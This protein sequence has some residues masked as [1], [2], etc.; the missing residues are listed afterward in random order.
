MGRR[1]SSC[2]PACTLC[3]I[4]IFIKNLLEFTICFLYITSGGESQEFISLHFVKESVMKRSL[5]F[6]ALLLLIAAQLYGGERKRIPMY[7]RTTKSWV[8]FPFYTIHDIEFVSQDS[9]LKA[10]TL[11]DNNARWTLQASRFGIAPAINDNDSEIVT[12]GLVV[13]P[14]FVITYTGGGLT[15]LLH[16][17]INNYSNSWGGILLRYPVA[18]TASWDLNGYGSVEKGDLIYVTAKVNDYPA[19]YMNSTTELVPDTNYTTTVVGHNIPIPA[20]TLVDITDLNHGAYNS[21]G[22]FSKPYSIAEQY[23]NSL[24]ELTGLAVTNYLNSGRQLVL[25]GAGGNQLTDYDWSYYF[26]IGNAGGA[27]DPNFHQP[28]VGAVMDTIRG[29]LGTTSGNENSDGYRIIPLYP[30]DIVWGVTLPL[31]SAHRRNPVVVTPNDSVQVQVSMAL[32]SGGLPLYKCVIVK[33]I[34]YG[35]WTVDTLG[36]Y[37]STSNPDSTIYA[38]YILDQDG[39]PWPLGTNVRYFF[40][41]IDNFGDE[42]IYANASGSFGRD[43]TRGFFFYNVGNGSL[44]IHDV[45]YTPYTNGRSAYAGGVTSLS[46]IV[47]ADTTVM[48]LSPL[49]AT[50]TGVG[51]NA[52]YIQNGSGPWNGIWVISTDSLSAVQLAAMRLG[53]SVVVYGA[54]EE[55]FEVTTL[56]DSTVAIVAHNRP[57]PAPVT[58]TTATLGVRGNGDP[59]GEQWEGCLVRV[60]NARFMDTAAYYTNIT[61]YG[62]DDGTGEMH[63]LRDGRNNYSNHGADTISGDRIFNIGDRVDTMIGIV[64]YSYNQYKLVPRSNADIVA[65]EPFQYQKDWNLVSVGRDQQPAIGAYTQGNLF[66]GSLGTPFA[67]EGRYVPVTTTLA[68]DEGYWLKFPAT[69]TIRQL[70][71]KHT[72]DFIP[73]NPGWNIIGAIGDSVPVSPV[74]PS[75]PGN[76]LS[77][78]FGYSNGYAIPAQLKPSQGYWVK[79]AVR[80]SLLVSSQHAMPKASP[81][82]VDI[83]QFNTLTITDN[84]GSAQT[85]FFGQDADGKLP[86][87]SFEL[88]PPGPGSRM[89]VRFS[90][91]RI[92]E[93]HPATLVAP[94]DYPIVING[95]QAPLKVKWNIVNPNGKKYTLSDGVN[96]KLFKAAAI[97]GAGEMTLTKVPPGLMLSAG[98]GAALPKEFSLGQNY[99]NPFN[100]TTSFVVGLP[101]TA[102]L[103]I[104]VYNILGQKVATLVDEERSAG[105]QTITWNGA[106]QSGLSVSSGVYFVRMTAEPSNGV[107][108]PFIGLRKIV[109][110][111]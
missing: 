59:V 76:T 110:M 79:S 4:N 71:V 81:S 39:N 107:G 8:S 5:L 43:T 7:N 62:I 55:N 16:D 84:S 44:T 12:L 70:G 102:H 95:G 101:Q 66:P 108:R 14:Q 63:V 93:A 94:V 68:F 32:E 78:F 103:Q 80:D 98:A 34:N 13:C 87:A 65:G 15:M 106:S 2:L 52:Y 33:S 77:H 53:D 105:F 86:L 30:G 92:L 48:R 73:V 100:P 35:P 27:G 47:T 51:T 49:S 96:G 10:D 109:M 36:Y 56:F 23:E 50:P 74:V 22:P 41:G 88:P 60:V 72:H 42:G 6:L 46:G 29:T 82:A 26:T 83:G 104:I 1:L 64:Y 24:I 45:Q 11:G 18:D 89:D 54:I 67:Y 38:E 91:G 99:P 111:K 75:T 19:N 90:T 20:P 9:L 85:L 28:P 57:Q 17:T 25:T 40:K 69:T 97:T 21:T 61:E 37:G 3:R 58:I 31:V